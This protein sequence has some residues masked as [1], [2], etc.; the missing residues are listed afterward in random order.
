[1]CGTSTER[2]NVSRTNVRREENLPSCQFCRQ[3]LGNL[4]DLREKE[5]ETGSS[6]KDQRGREAK[7]IDCCK[8]PKHPRTHTL[9]HT[10]TLA[11]SHTRTLAHLHT[12]TLA[13]LHT[14]TLAPHHNTRSGA[15]ARRTMLCHQLALITALR[16]ALVSN[17][18]R[19]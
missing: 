15:H 10:R 8:A 1:L 13:H 3:R 2:T 18:P 9:T 14:C 7:T 17:V 12:C 11:H 5:R 4:A 6:A 16:T 19:W